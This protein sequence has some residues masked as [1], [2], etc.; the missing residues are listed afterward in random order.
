MPTAN[1]IDQ[2]HEMLRDEFYNSQVRKILVEGDSWVCHPL[3][4]YYSIARQLGEV[5]Q[6]DTLV[7]NVGHWGDTARELF[8]A[9]TRSY[10]QMETLLSSNSDGNEFDL[11]VLSAGGNDILECLPKEN[12]PLLI[13]HDENPNLA[14]EERLS[15]TFY[16]L[17][18][19]IERLYNGMFALRDASTLNANTP[20]LLFPYAYFKPR[21]KGTTVLNQ[22][23]SEGWVAKGCSMK[24]IKPAHWQTI[25]V[26]LIDTF[27][28]MLKRL[29]AANTNVLVVDTRTRLTNG[30]RPLLRYFADEIHP[31]TQ[32]FRRLARS[33]KNAAEKAGYW[34]IE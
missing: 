26:T 4:G 32:G 6:L 24:G 5:D 11:M 20:I 27:Y 15:D 28:N 17:V 10:R 30:E 1:S 13:G 7:L 25:A 8:G 21:F 31:N 9:D 19:E 23:F 34:A 29:E 14:P 3:P 2:F 16:Q 33:L 12:C 18:D 22:S